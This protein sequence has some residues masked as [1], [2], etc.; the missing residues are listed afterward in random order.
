MLNR[1][2]IHDSIQCRDQEPVEVILSFQNND[3][4]TDNNNIVNIPPQ[5]LETFGSNVYNFDPI[6]VQLASNVASTQSPFARRRSSNI[7]HNDILM[8]LESMKNQEIVD[9]N[10]TSEEKQEMDDDLEYVNNDIFIKNDIVKSDIE[11]DTETVQR[12]DIS[13]KNTAQISS[14]LK[15]SSVPLAVDTLPGYNILRLF[16]GG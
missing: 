10:K 9:V 4:R 11:E 3:Y 7:H 15:Q 14:L 12:A 13:E 16:T 2:Y 6:K 5:L 8:A 1:E